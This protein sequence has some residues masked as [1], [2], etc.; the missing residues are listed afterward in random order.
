MSKIVRVSDRSD[1]IIKEIALRTGKAKTE[2]IELALETY[3]RVERMNALNEGYKKLRDD[4]E[5]WEKELKKRDELEGTL[6]DGL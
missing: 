2:V 3:R 6:L 5:S 4:K 1:S